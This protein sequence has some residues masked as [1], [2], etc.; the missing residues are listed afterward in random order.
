MNRIIILGNLT[1]DPVKK[2]LEN[3]DDCSVVNFIVAV[4]RPKVGDKKQET[5]YFPVVAWRGLADTCAKYLK[6]GSKVLI[7]GSMQ[8]RNYDAADGTHR[9]MAELIADEIQFLSPAGKP[10]ELSTVE[11]AKGAKNG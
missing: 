7:S 10:E 4:N 3:K 1:K 2:V 11:N 5:D 9:Y 8:M 6:K